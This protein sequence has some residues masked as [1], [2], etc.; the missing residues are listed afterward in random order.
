[1]SKKKKIGNFI[2]LFDKAKIGH[3]DYLRRIRENGGIS[4]NM[5]AFCALLL[6]AA[7]SHAIYVRII[8]IKDF[9]FSNISFLSFV[10]I[11]FGAKEI[12]KNFIPD[13]VLY[14]MKGEFFIELEPPFLL[15]WIAGLAL[16]NLVVLLFI[17]IDALSWIKRNGK[18]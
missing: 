18:K 10:A 16:A 3:G 9:V 14:F 1:M 4:H 17:P 12:F 7:L 2:E 6:F 11:L 15:R 5:R 8:P 13:W